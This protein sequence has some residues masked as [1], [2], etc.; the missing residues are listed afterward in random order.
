M[1]VSIIGAGIVGSSMRK[2]F[3]GAQVIDPA[4][5][6]TGRIRGGIAFVC[7][8]TPMAPDGSCDTSIVREVVTSHDPDIVVIR[9]TVPP[10][11]SRHLGAVFQPEYL[12]MTPGHRYESDLDVPFVILGG[13]EEHTKVVRDL[14]RTVLPPD[15]AYHL[16]SSDAAELVK[17]ATN[18]YLATKVEF[19]N[20][21]S[22]ACRSL[23]LDYDELRELWLLDDRIGRSHTQGG[24]PFGGACF[25]KDIAAFVHWAGERGVEVPVIRAA[26][27]SNNRRT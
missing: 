20:E 8:P 24:K 1:D 21:L 15:T 22:D 14:Y 23:G 3:P 19:A 6:L 16:T 12:G 26:M 25:P 18:T 9:S 17:Y 11:T 27:E 5:G 4:K 10:G 13:P 2:V 7:V